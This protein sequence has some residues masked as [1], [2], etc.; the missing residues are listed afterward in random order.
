M[1]VFMLALL[2]SLQDRPKM[3]LI[4]GTFVAV[5]GLAYSAFMA[6]WLNMFLLVGLSRLSEVILGAIASVAGVIN[7]KDFWA[8]RHGV[9]LEI[10]E[11]AKPGLYTKI[12]DIVQAKN[13]TAALVGAVELAVL[14]QVVEFLCTAGFPVLY[15]RILTMRQLEWSAYYG[16]LLLSNIAYMLDDVIVLTIGVVTLSQRRLQEREGRWLKL[17][18]GVVMLGLGIALIAK[19]EWLT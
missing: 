5:E 4:A 14:V 2:A 6:A 19:P 8:F 7:A 13:L 10:P 16:Y 9:S 3:L 1:L 17:M 18:S 11:A 12:R 15:T